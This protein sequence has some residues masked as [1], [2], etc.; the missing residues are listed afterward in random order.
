[1]NKL[2]TMA[3]PSNPRAKED[4]FPILEQSLKLE[5]SGPGKYRSP[6]LA[7]TNIVEIRQK[8]IV[9]LM[10]EKV[11]D[12]GV[13]GDD[14]ARENLT[15]WISIT[16]PY[17]KDVLGVPVCRMKIENPAQ[18]RYLA[19]EEDALK[20]DE[21]FYFGNKKAYM[22]LADEDLRSAVTSYPK[23][24]YISLTQAGFMYCD[25]ANVFTK[26]C[27]Y[28]FTPQT[29]DGQVESYMRN[30]V[31]PN[32][33]FAFDLVRSGK[34]AKNFGLVPVRKPVLTVYPAIWSGGKIGAEKTDPYR[35]EVLKKIKARVKKNIALIDGYACE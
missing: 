3:L 12:I 20:F 8:D 11:I 22:N 28:A 26:D 30:G 9:K 21:D 13:F 15:E 18:L 6:Y 19:R 4:S 2:I 17:K 29:V 7:N 32:T 34:T 14:V 31:Y 16:E 35:E 5:R 10:R 23:N 1:M 24:L 33:V 25:G 27:N